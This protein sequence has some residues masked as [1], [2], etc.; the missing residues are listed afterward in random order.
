MA[1]NNGIFIILSGKTI[2]QYSSSKILQMWLKEI[3]Y[4]VEARND[5]KNVSKFFPF[6]EDRTTWTYFYKIVSYIFI[7]ITLATDLHFC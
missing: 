5:C 3:T 6:Y 4:L 1:Y 7:D 2:Q